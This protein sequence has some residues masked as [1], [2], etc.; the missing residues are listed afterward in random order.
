MGLPQAMV[1]M[2]C[3]DKEVLQ[4]GISGELCFFKNQDVYCLDD[5][6]FTHE[7]NQPVER[8]V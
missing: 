2:V 1:S 6:R 3:S 7:G 4:V 5:L 8:V